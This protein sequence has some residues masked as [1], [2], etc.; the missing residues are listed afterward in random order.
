MAEPFVEKLV[1]S[2]LCDV[3]MLSKSEVNTKNGQ[4]QQKRK[5]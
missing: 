5:Q 1:L 4:V 3:S 2:Y